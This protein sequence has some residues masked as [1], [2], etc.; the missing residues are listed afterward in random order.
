MMSTHYCKKGNINSNQTRKLLEHVSHTIKKTAKELEEAA[1]D[2]LSSKMI[3]VTEIISD[4]RSNIII[5][6]ESSE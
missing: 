3:E 4:N 1:E 2:L 5:E 6:D